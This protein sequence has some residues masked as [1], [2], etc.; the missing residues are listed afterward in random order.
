MCVLHDSRWPDAPYYQ[1]FALAE[2]CIPKALQ[3]GIHDYQ[4][5]AINAA[6][7]R[8]LFLRPKF[9]LTSSQLAA[10][11]GIHP[12]NL[13]RSGHSDVTLQDFARVLRLNIAYFY[14]E[15]AH[16][17]AAAARQLIRM[18]TQFL[19]LSD[20]IKDIKTI[21]QQVRMSDTR[22]RQLITIGRAAGALSELSWAEAMAYSQ[23]IVECRKTPS[24]L[25]DAHRDFDLHPSIINQVAAHLRGWSDIQC[26]FSAGQISALHAL[27]A[28]PRV[29][30]MP[31]SEFATPSTIAHA[32]NSA[33]AK[34]KPI[35]NVVFR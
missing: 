3:E 26:Q 17:I 21:A 31:L 16:Y 18:V 23:C 13:H 7:G 34:L 14:P 8:G 6:L 30:R 19:R 28:A 9:A 29:N 12:A 33:D 32:I 10:A 35:L 11:V 22:V 27:G 24:V 20:E 25:R 2:A 5:K 15:E 1:T 4:M